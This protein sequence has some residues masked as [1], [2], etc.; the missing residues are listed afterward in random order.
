MSYV[1][2]MPCL[3]LVSVSVL[4]RLY[5]ELRIANKNLF[6]KPVPLKISTTGGV[7]MIEKWSMMLVIDYVCPSESDFTAHNILLP[8]PHRRGNMGFSAMLL[9]SCEID[10]KKENYRKISI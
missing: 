9:I 10:E 3:Y 5:K 7:V 2:V 8:K 1:G 4:L 6:T